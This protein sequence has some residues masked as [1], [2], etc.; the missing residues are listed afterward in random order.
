MEGFN[1]H[2]TLAEQEEELFN[3]MLNNT[4]SDDFVKVASQRNNILAEIARLQD[5]SKLTGEDRKYRHD[6]FSH[7]SVLPGTNINS[8]RQ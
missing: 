6:Q 7:I 4:R 3:W 1:E 5:D 2:K 8:F